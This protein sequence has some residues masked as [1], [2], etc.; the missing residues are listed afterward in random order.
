MLK[1]YRNVT[2]S[3]LPVSLCTIPK[4]YPIMI[5]IINTGLF[6]ATTFVF[7]AFTMEKGQLHA[8]H[9]NINISHIELIVF[10][11]FYFLNLDMNRSLSTI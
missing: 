6:P 9:S 11:K 1:T 4:T 10:I 8:K 2:Q 3:A 7:N 5:I